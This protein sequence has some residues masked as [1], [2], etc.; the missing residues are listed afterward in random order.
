MNNVKKA[1]IGAMLGV[2]PTITVAQSAHTAG[3][4]VFLD[5][6]GNGIL[7]RGERGIR[8]V[9]VSNGIDVVQTDSR[10]RYSIPLLPESILFITQPERYQ[11][12]VDENNLPQ[13]YYIHYPDGTPPVAAFEF[14]VIEPTGPLPASIDFPLLRG[15]TRQKTFK[16]MGFADPQARTDEFQDQ[17]REDII[18]ELIGNPY[19]AAFGLVAGDVVD[20]NLALYPRHNAMMG[21][22]GF[23]IWNVPGNHDINFR[24]P[25]DRYSTETFKRYFGP[26]NFSF[27]YGDVHF[28][29][30]DNVEYKGDGQGRFD[31][32]IYRGYI[33]PDQLQWLSNDL[34]FVPRDKLIVIMTHISL[35][36]YAL[37]GQ[38]ERFNQGDNI[39]TVNLNELVEILKPFDRVY[40]IAGHDTSNSWKIQLDHTHGWFGDWFLVHT[41]AEVRGNGWSRGPRDER[42]VRLA[43]MQDGNPNGYYVF[44]F[45][46]T[47]VQ[48]RFIPAEG[49]PNETMRIVLDP[50]LEGTRDTEG[51]VLAINRGAALP[52]TKIVV[53]LFDGGERDLVEVS[54]DDSPYAP[55]EIVLRNDPFMERLAE[56]FR[57]TPDAFSSPQPSSHI[58]EYPLPELA[59]GLHT[60]K[61]RA[62][63]EFGQQ[64][65][66]AFS[67]E[68][69]EAS[70]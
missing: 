38:G 10:G 51:N 45:D 54:I 21:K 58:W 12:P 2:L 32:T 60:V 67:F 34:Q 50:L 18:N 46:G 48:P 22:L 62:L 3:G 7:D 17:L 66:K 33:S 53:N 64:S 65:S 24:S 56:R 29:G 5:D 11:V 23:P 30:L 63:D 37:D 14:P 49:D 26:P 69:T 28:I 47:D 44:S 8:G 40:A 16:A 70:Q 6:N 57:D 13:F 39:N 15:E 41:L 9:S 27:D 4:V 55:M 61:V 20:D 36:T 35:I 43:T 25:N 19:G 68:L 1:L 59:A 52:G 31:N 42:D